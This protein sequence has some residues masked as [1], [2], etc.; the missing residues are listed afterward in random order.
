VRERERERGVNKK[1]VHR[2]MEECFEER[3]QRKRGRERV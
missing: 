1:R 3:A 2:E